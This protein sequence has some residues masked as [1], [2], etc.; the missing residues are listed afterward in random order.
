MAL[1][2]RYSALFVPSVPETVA[3]Y[4]RAFGFQLRYMHPSSGY[5][6][7]ETGDTLLAFVGGDFIE[8]ANLLG[9]LRFEANRPAAAA[10]LALV[11]DDMDGDWMRA[12]SAGATVVKAPEL[13]P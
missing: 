5:A 6:E 13:K 9:E 11:T 4:E 2:F 1:K 8:T 10:Q 12:L 7:L 3:F